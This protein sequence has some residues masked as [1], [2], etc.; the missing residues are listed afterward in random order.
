M[1]GW[2]GQRGEGQRGAGAAGRGGGRRAGGGR[3]TAGGSAG[4]GGRSHL[5]AEF[6]PALHEAVLAL[7][8]AT[9]AD[10][11]LVHGVDRVRRVKEEAAVG[12]GQ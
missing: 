10:G 8:A 5:E 2:E 11:A 7:G 6:G 3:R 12:V 4:G 9:G 1:E